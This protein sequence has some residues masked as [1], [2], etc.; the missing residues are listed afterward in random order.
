[1]SNLAQRVLCELGQKAPA[2]AREQIQKTAHW[3]AVTCSTPGSYSHEAV[4]KALMQ[5]GVSNEL[6]IDTCI[7]E[8]CPYAGSGL[9]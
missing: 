9:E 8:G 6:L 7:P 3:L 1:M 4:L 2:E 5:K